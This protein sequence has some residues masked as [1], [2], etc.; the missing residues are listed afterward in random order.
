MRQANLKVYDL[1][2]KGGC[3]RKKQGLE[4][5]LKVFQKKKKVLRVSEKFN[6][7]IPKT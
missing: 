6:E 3:H 5:E 7:I 4:Q 2:V 1:W